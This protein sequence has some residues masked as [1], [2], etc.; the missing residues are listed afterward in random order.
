M[1]STW[2]AWRCMIVWEY[3]CV[4]LCVCVCAHMFVYY[5]L[6][7]SELSVSS[8]LSFLLGISIPELWIDPWSISW[9]WEKSCM[10]LSVTCHTHTHECTCTHT[11]THIN[12][13]THTQTNT[14]KHTQTHINTHIHTHTHT[15]TRCLIIFTLNFIYFILNWVA[16]YC[17]AGL[18]RITLANGG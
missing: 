9:V 13:H 15:H 14:H 10:S 4:C 11:N 12:T 8:S 7:T 3:A 6:L 18:L 16:F 2:D 5:M 1:H 17:T